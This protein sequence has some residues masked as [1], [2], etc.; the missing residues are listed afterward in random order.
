MDEKMG[1]YSWSVLILTKPLRHQ[2]GDNYYFTVTVSKPGTN[3]PTKKI[4][5]LVWSRDDLPDC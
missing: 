4:S 5:K 2:T 1:Q 3:N